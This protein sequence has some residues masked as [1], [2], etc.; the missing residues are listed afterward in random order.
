M[1][2]EVFIGGG[3]EKGL[4]IHKRK[5]R[6]SKN[7]TDKVVG[8]LSKMIVTKTGLV[9]YYQLVKEMK[10]EVNHVYKFQLTIDSGTEVVRE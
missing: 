1:W 4:G 9:I 2:K 5:A 10:L 8:R 7:M 3:E 6:G